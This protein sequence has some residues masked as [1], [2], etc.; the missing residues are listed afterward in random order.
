MQVVEKFKPLFDDDLDQRW[1]V[2]W[3]G[4]ASAK[5]YSAAQKVLLDTVSKNGQKWLVS[6]K[7]FGTHKKSTFSLIK[8]IA[9]K[10]NLLGRLKINNNELFISDKKTKSEILFIGLD[11]PQKLKSING[12]T[13]NWM[14]EPTEMTRRDVEE[15]NQRLRVKG[16]NI[17]TFNPVS[18]F[19][20]IKDYF[21]DHNYHDPLKI[22]S[23]YHDN[24]FIADAYIEELEGLKVVDE[25]LYNVAALGQWGSVQDVVFH[26]WVVLSEDTEPD[27]FDQLYVG[28]DFGFNHPSVAL[29]IGIRDDEIYVLNE[30]FIREKVN[31]VFI[32]L[33]NKE[34]PQAKDAY[35]RGD[36][37]AP[38]LIAEFRDAG[39]NF[40]EG[41]IKG[42]GSVESA[43]DWLKAHK[44]N[45]NPSCLH[46]IRELQTYSYLRLR[47]ETLSDSKFQPTGDDCI[48]ALRYGTEYIRRF[49]SAGVIEVI[50]AF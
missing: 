15:V 47:D 28:L 38:G 45:V 49:K 35:G 36:S 2:C 5:S 17:L 22:H 42:S 21:F 4:Y 24:R 37:A 6:R 31:A 1:I 34:I 19:H 46:T 18:E 7:V 32:D 13:G 12:I 40:L 25:N 3:G 10:N 33:V 16:K 11:D 20:W 50:P 39:Y 9:F 14:E 29:L 8:E 43:I 30:V 41:T 26:N 44:I 23:T 27:S 48:A